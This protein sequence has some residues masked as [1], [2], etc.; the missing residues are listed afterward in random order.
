MTAPGNITIVAVHGAW[1]DGSSWKDVIL[2]LEREDL[3]VIAAPIPLTS[4][5]DD[6]AATLLTIVSLSPDWK[7]STVNLRAPL[8][9]NASEMRGA[10]AVLMTSNYKLSEPLPHG[11]DSPDAVDS[12]L[13]EQQVMPKLS[14]R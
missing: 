12:N 10:Q 8:F 14:A 1:A 4:L 7:K 3:R 2:S 9:I 6:A 11:W 5:G 13:T